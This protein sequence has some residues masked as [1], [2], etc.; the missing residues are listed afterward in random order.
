MTYAESSGINFNVPRQALADSVNIAIKKMPGSDNILMRT[1]SEF[2][3]LVSL[4]DTRL[5]DLTFVFNTIA[6]LIAG[7]IFS[8]NKKLI[9]KAIQGNGKAADA[10]AGFMYD[11]DIANEW[12]MWAIAN[13]YKCGEKPDIELVVADDSKNNVKS[14]QPNDICEEYYEP[15]EPCS[16]ADNA[17]SKPDNNEKIL[18]ALQYHNKVSDM[19]LDTTKSIDKKIEK[20]FSNQTA[21]A[22]NTKYSSYDKSGKTSPHIFKKIFVFMMI[23]A[24][25][26]ILYLVNFTNKYFSGNYTAEMPELSTKQSKKKYNIAD[27]TIGTTV[28]G[29][30]QR[31]N[32]KLVVIIP[33]RKGYDIPIKIDSSGMLQKTRWWITDSDGRVVKN[34]AC[35]GKTYD[36]FTAK[37]DDLYKLIVTGAR[38]SELT[39]SIG[40]KI[41][42]FDMVM[43]YINKPFF[44]L[45]QKLL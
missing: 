38:G 8:Q 37:N 24:V 44:A 32:E 4:C 30:I 35:T 26:D 28:T 9:I 10:V 16:R 14:L 6:C 2:A 33:I 25:I 15:D 13:G 5:T 40:E 45:Y 36:V 18:Q 3:P 39:F 42:T 17:C 20:S 11:K 12:H 31:K 22:D 7:G 27:A 29:I 19:V 21:R 23:L 34:G 1:L 41:N 43:Y